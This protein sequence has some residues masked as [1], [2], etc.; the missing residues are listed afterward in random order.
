MHSCKDCIRYPWDRRFPPDN[1]PA[2]K[3]LDPPEGEG[4]KKWTDSI[5]DAE[6]ELA[7][8]DDGKPKVAPPAELTIEELFAKAEALGVSVDKRW[9]A[10]TLLEKIAEAEAK[11]AASAAASGSGEGAENVGAGTV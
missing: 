8:F 6:N 10:A 5:R 1:L 4:F 3:C 11:K 7:C 2:A 9:K